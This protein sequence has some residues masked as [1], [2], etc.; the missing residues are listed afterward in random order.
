MLCFL[1]AMGWLALSPIQASH[2]VSNCLKNDDITIYSETGLEMSCLESK[3]RRD[4]TF[5]TLQ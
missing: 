5:F 3:L 1:S 4:Q 2:F